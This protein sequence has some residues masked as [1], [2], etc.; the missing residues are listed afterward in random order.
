MRC[1]PWT[2]GIDI[3]AD[4]V[5]GNDVLEEAEPELGHGREDGA[6]AGDGRGQDDVERRDAIRGDDQ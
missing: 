5:V 3:G 2:H 1:H 4:E 6:L